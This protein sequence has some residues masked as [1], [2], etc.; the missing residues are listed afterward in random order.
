MEVNQLPEKENEYTF[1]LGCSCRTEHV[2]AKTLREAWRKT[3]KIIESYFPDGFKKKTIHEKL[4][5]VSDFMPVGLYQFARP[6]AGTMSGWIQT[7]DK[8]VRKRMDNFKDKVAIL[9]KLS[10]TE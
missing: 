9:W 3:E 6:G 10:A 8:I 2:K 4:T 5:K 7:Y 1:L